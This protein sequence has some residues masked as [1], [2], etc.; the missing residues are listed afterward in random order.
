MGLL[1]LSLIGFSAV[2]S[3]ITINL[4]FFGKGEREKE[5]LAG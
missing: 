4:D 5:V 2:V 1:S 3:S